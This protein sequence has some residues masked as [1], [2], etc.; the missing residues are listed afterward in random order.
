MSKYLYFLSLISLVAA[1]LVACDDD[2]ESG[3]EPIVVNP[4]AGEMS[5]GSDSDPNACSTACQ[6][7]LACETWSSCPDDQRSKALTQ[8]LSDCEANAEEIISLSQLICDVSTEQFGQRYRLNDCAQSSDLCEEQICGTGF[9]CDPSNG[10]CIDP[11]IGVVCAAG[12]E[13]VEGVCEDPCANL[14]CPEG[15]G[16]FAG[17]CTDLCFGVNCGANQECDTSTGQCID[18]CGDVTCR[19]GNRCVDGQCIPA[20]QDVVCEEGLSCDRNTGE[21]ID[22]CE[23]VNCAEGFTCNPDSGFCRDSCLGVSCVD[24]WVCDAGNCVYDTPCTDSMCTGENICSLETGRCERFICNPDALEGDL[25][26]NSLP[27]AVQLNSITQR[28]DNLTICSFDF[29]WFAFTLPA[30]QEG[31]VSIRFED[32]AGDLTLRMYTSSNLLTPTIEMNTQDDD[33]FIGLFASDVDQRF[34]FR[35]SA[36]DGIQENRYSLVIELDL[37]G[38]VCNEVSDCDNAREC[39]NAL[40]DGRG[41]LNPNPGTVDPNNPSDP[42]NPI[43]PV[44]TEEESEPNDDYDEATPLAPLN[45]G[46]WTGRICGDNT[47]FYSIVLDEASDL[48]ILL[49][50]AHAEGDLDLNLTDESGASVSLGVSSDDDERI[51][52]E[53]LAAGQ[54]YLIVYSFGGRSNNDYSITIDQSPASEEMN[55]CSIDEECRWDYACVSGN[56]VTPEGYCDDIT[57]PNA[58]YSQAYAIE[59]P[60]NFD[61]L[62]F[63]STDFYALSLVPDQ[64]VTIQ[65]RFSN[66]QGEDLDLV[67]YR[68]DGSIAQASSG[69]D[70]SEV[71]TYTADMAGIHTLEVKGYF[72]FTESLPFIT[73]YTLDV[74]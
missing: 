15:L 57:S 21:C 16:C 32:H 23:N 1:P 50:F 70:E 9:I 42:N 55:E 7:L 33:E 26:N 25:T 5:A 48:E 40:C 51:F 41:D 2:E 24:G 43:D 69:T 12:I 46:S 19:R 31:R 52:V 67:F 36:I 56:C 64:E 22:R 39:T 59:I 49:N 74:Q 47:D 17:S 18:Q 8:C 35:V 30:N 34:Y 10:Q 28:I 65:V 73:T 58:E 11:C 6:S 61:N 29:D 71:I 4:M 45:D 44:C 3:T 54:Y 63:C 14:E 53:N 37:P 38:A 62:S 72:G 60:S 27:Q 68:P 66:D 20:C 13:C